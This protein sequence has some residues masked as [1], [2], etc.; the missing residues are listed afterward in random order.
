MRLDYSAD[1]GHDLASGGDTEVVPERRRDTDGFVLS[2]FFV[3]VAV[4]KQPPVFK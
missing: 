4:A 1:D 2:G 3:T